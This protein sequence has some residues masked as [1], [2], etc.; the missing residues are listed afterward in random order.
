MHWQLHLDVRERKLDDRDEGL[1]KLMR[2][3]WVK[4]TTS[5]DKDAEIRWMERE[6]DNSVLRAREE[7]QREIE[8]GVCCVVLCL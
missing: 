4:E 6:I 8:V 1:S 2:E 5:V 7:V 3:L